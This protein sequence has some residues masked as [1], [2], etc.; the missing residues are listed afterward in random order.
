MSAIFQLGP[1]VYGKFT[2]NGGSGYSFAYTRLDIY[3]SGDMYATKEDFVLVSRDYVQDATAWSTGVGRLTGNAYIEDGVTSLVSKMFKT[4]ESPGIEHNMYIGNGIT[5]IPEYFCYNFGGTHEL[6]YALRWNNIYFPNGC[7]VETV[8]AYAF[9]GQSLLENIELNA[10]VEYYYQSCFYACYMLE[11]FASGNNTIDGYIGLGAFQHCRALQHLTFTENTIFYDSVNPNVYAC[12]FLNWNTGVD[13]DENGWL[14][15]YIHGYIGV[16][17]LLDWNDA[18]RHPQFD[19]VGKEI[20][21]LMHN[22]IMHV[23]RGYD[24][25]HLP[26][27]HKG[28]IYWLRFVADG[29]PKQSPLVIRHKGT[30]HYISK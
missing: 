7:N 26:Q 17:Q 19:Q 16:A 18:Q 5:D 9:L 8:G 27:K 23:I 1:N 22:N 30:L 10:T 4:N 25:G 12:F 15:T 24:S 28:R 29:D 11:H 13:C 21:R 20:Y 14:Y 2:D 3:G 6:D